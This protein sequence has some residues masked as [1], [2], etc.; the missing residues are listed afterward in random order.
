MEKC[1][2]KAGAFKISDDGCFKEK[3]AG[4]PVYTTDCLSSKVVSS[5]V[6]AMALGCLKGIPRA[7]EGPSHPPL[8]SFR[9]AVVICLDMKE[10][11]TL[12]SQNL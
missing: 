11:S 6:F 1:E 12:W 3:A 8:L 10:P 4:Y 7:V 5:A 2:I 9:R